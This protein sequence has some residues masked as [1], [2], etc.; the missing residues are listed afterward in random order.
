MHFQNVSMFHLL[1][2]LV[3][4]V[5][6][7]AFNDSSKML[8][9]KN[10]SLM[11]H[12]RLGNKWFYQTQIIK[13]CQNFSL[14]KKMQLSPTVKIVNQLKPTPHYWSERKARNK[15]LAN[16]FSEWSPAGKPL[17]GIAFSV[18]EAALLRF[19]VRAMQL[20]MFPQALNNNTRTD[21]FSQESFSMKTISRNS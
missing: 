9:V 14:N 8:C 16:V 6:L 15:N 3:F 2:S 19:I 5:L 7:I 11:T 13:Q 12:V 21:G 10:V 4:C 20:V 17:P 18:H 1:S